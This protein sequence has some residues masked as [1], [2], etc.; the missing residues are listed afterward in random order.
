MMKEAGF[1]SR[2]IRATASDIVSVFGRN[3][4]LLRRVD[5]IDEMLTKI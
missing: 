5:N 3:E 4:R 2:L 1:D